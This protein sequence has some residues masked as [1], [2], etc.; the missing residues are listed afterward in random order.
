VRSPE[1]GSVIGAFFNCNG[2][3]VLAVESDS[4]RDEGERRVDGE[5]F[6]R[7]HVRRF[8]LA[9]GNCPAVPGLFSAAAVMHPVI[10]VACSVGAV[11]KARPSVLA[12]MVAKSRK[13]E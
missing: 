11:E 5:D 10:R 9:H 3:L 13:S 1:Q 8:A 2:L 12:D 4:Q 6:V 7:E